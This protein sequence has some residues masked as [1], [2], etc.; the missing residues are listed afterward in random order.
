MHRSIS[1]VA[2]MRFTS[3]L[4]LVLA[5][6]A[7]PAVSPA[8]QIGKVSMPDQ[9]TVDGEALTLNGAGTVRY[10]F[11]KID[12]YTAALYLRKTDRS[13]QSILGSTTP[14]VMH[15]RF[16]RDVSQKDTVRAW[17]VYFESNC[18]SPCVLPRESIAAFNALVPPSN[19]GDTQTYVFK[20]D[21]I[22]FSNNGKLLGTVRGASSRGCC[23]PP[24]SVRRPRH[25]S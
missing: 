24:G 11:L 14:K 18:Q 12:V 13:E 23:Y 5:A 6:L 10:R 22:E 2:I 19:E 8:A 7:I 20:P 4:L 3:Q 17:Q 1:S 16:L 21:S 25:R 15:L 9:W